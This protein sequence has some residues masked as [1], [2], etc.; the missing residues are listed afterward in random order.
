MTI[1]DD[2]VICFFVMGHPPSTIGLT[3]G[4]WTW[5]SDFILDSVGAVPVFGARVHTISTS[6]TRDTHALL[7]TLEA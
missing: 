1:D 2:D 6:Q 3:S 4:E 7:R 5:H